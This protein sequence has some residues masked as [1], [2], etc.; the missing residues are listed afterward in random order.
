[1]RPQFQLPSHSNYPSLIA[2][3]QPHPNVTVSDLID[4]KT[5]TVDYLRE[6]IQSFS[7]YVSGFMLLDA[8]ARPTAGGD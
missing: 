3:C 2:A 8:G 1:M 4:L 7:R 5:R 6:V